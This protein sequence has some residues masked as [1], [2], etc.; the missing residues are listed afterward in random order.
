MGTCNFRSETKDLN[1]LNITNISINL[2]RFNYP[3]GKGGFGKV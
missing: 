1:E 3:I 2:F